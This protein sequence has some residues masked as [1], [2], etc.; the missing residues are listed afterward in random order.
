MCLDQVDYMR[1]LLIYK[2]G[3]IWLDSDTI[4]LTSL[5]E[6]FDILQ[7]QDGFFINDK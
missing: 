1:I 5:K 3:G 6:L 2:Y 7:E 4:V